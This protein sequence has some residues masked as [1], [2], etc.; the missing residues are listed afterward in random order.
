MTSQTENPN[1]R[2]KWLIIGGGLLG[3]L[4]IGWLVLTSGPVVKALV[5]P[6]VAAALQ[7]DLTVG[8]LRLS[9]FSGIDLKNVTL[10][11]IGGQPLAEIAGVKVRYHLFKLLGGEIAVG[12]IELNQ[13]RFTVRQ[14]ADGGSDLTDWL[15]KLGGGEAEPAEAPASS[16]PLQLQIGKVT[17]RDGSLRYEIDG[18][19]GVRQLATINSL[20]LAVDQVRNGRP[21]EAKLTASL[22]VESRDATGVLVDSLWAGLELSS[23][24]ALDAGLAPGQVDTRLRLDVREATGRFAQGAE[25]SAQLTARGSLPQLDEFAL[26]FQKSAAEVGRVQVTGSYDPAAGAGAFD[27]TIAKL[28]PIMLE[29]AALQTGLTFKLGDFAATNRVV[30]AG[31]GD[32][33]NAS[34]RLSLEQFAAGN[35]TGSTPLLDVSLD[36]DTALEFA[37]GRAL[38]R[39]FA[40]SARQDGRALVEA[41]VAQPFPFAWAGQPGGEAGGSFALKMDRLRLSDW[42]AFSGELPLDGLF[43]VEASIDSRELGQQLELQAR[44]VLTGVATDGAPAQAGRELAALNT[45][46]R[47]TLAGSTVDLLT[48]ANVDLPAL[49]ALAGELPLKLQ[50][51]VLNYQGAVHHSAAATKLSGSLS[52]TNLTGE[53]E[54]VVLRQL[55]VLLPHEVS[56]QGD[57]LEWQL[58]EAGVTEAGQSALQLVSSGKLD[59]RNTTGSVALSVPLINERLVNPF[60]AVYAPQQR[61]R[62]ATASLAITGELRA[63]G[64]QDWSLTSQSTNVVVV[65]TNGV[66]LAPRLGTLASLNLAF[67]PENGTVILKNWDAQVFAEGQ[68]SGELSATA[69]V[70]LKEGLAKVNARLSGVNEHTLQPLA[71]LLVGDRTIERAKASAELEIDY[72]QTRPSQARAVFDLRDF[73]VRDARGPLPDMPRELGLNLRAAIAS[74]RLDLTEGRVRMTPTAGLSNEVSLTG[75]VDFAHAD[76]LSGD[77]TLRS[78]GFDLT[79]LYELMERGG[80]DTNTP[81]A[82]VPPSTPGEPAAGIFPLPVDRLALATDFRL[83]RLRELLITNWVTQATVRSNDVELGLFSLRLNGSPINARLQAT[84]EAGATR[85]ELAA[86]VERLPTGPLART[87]S[88]GWLGTAES[89]LFA[90]VRLGGTARPGQSL[91]AAANGDIH[92]GLTNGNFQF[93]SPRW[94]NTLRPV[95]LL[96]QTPALFS[97]PITWAYQRMHFTNQTLNL[98][99]FTVMSEAYLMNV[100]ATIPLTEDFTSSTIPRTPVNLHLSRNLVT[101]LGFLKGTDTNQTARY[102]EL[103]VFAHLGGTFAEPKVETDKLK[104]TGL[105]VGKAGDFVGGTAGDVLRKAGGLTEGLGGILSGRKLTGTEKEDANPVSR[106]I[107][108][109]FNAVGGVLGGTGRAVEQG[110]GVVTGTKTVE[111]DVLAT[112]VK[113][114]DWTRVFTNAPN[115]RTGNQ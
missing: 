79:L 54:G 42:R 8:E 81:S 62:S 99:Q 17:I 74:N 23:S 63:G 11:P 103:P 34:G 14:R 38:I 73:A 85:F 24:V 60:L 6:R 115:A 70:R 97:S 15:A 94:Q 28:P 53:L 112:K 47:V 98:E 45:T 75:W 26:V 16:E 30:I 82:T 68:P 19:D 3:L 48:T 114:F 64:L 101:Q 40:L 59:T 69:E 25:L 76:A 29:L 21:T 100:N 49:A 92:F 13:P 78:P 96:L 66:P 110:T 91:L 84:N 32:S 58:T 43:G 107:E 71:P 50:T 102:V 109:V 46:G 83:V 2:R 87:F 108:G 105:A 104:L 5:L 113:A 44:A 20:E 61:F 12:E 90:A 55:G 10:T 7:A 56:L 52:V 1:R 4:V 37:A 36:Y 77:L 35:A 57:T 27:L 106:G 33:I 9:P 86:E 65:G 18:A 93:L 67:H 39:Q 72:D 111:A 80:G 41:R 51:G 89:D 95:G 88:P 22:G 31:G